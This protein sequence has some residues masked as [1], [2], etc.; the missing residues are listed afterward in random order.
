MRKTKII[1]T[2]GPS[3][4]DV[5]VL[6]QMIEAGMNVARFN[7]SHGGHGDHAEKIALVRKAAA[8]QG[9]IVGLMMDT[10]GPEIRTGALKNGRVILQK[11]L[12]FNLTTLPV[13][14][15]EAK[16]S[17]TCRR[18]INDVK[19]GDIILIDDGLIRLTVENITKTDIVCQVVNGGEL[20]EHKGINVP[21]IVLDIPFM[22]E[23]DKEDILFA[24]EQRVD[25][26]AASFVRK[27]QDVLEIRKLLE[28]R[29]ADIDIIAKIE[30]RQGVDNLDEI[31]K[32]AD[33]I[34]V[35]RGDLGV[36]IP[37][38]E[39]PLVQKR[40][41]Q[42][43]AQSG[44]AVIVATQMLES[45]I[46]NPSPTRAEVSD[47]ATAVFESADAIMLSGETAKG[48]YPVEV[49]RTMS[50]IAERVEESFPYED[51]LRKKYI[52]EGISITDAISYACCST[53]LSLD[54]G[55][56]ISITN[57]GY[58]SKM[59]SKYRPKATI[60][61]ATPKEENI[62]KLTIVWGVYPILIS[63]HKNS[64][65]FFD[66]AVQRALDLE[67]V[68][69]GEK[70]VLSAGMPV[71]VSGA[72]NMMKVQV[73]AEILFH[74]T[75]IGTEPVSGKVKIIKSKEDL[76]KV[77]NEDIIVTVSANTDFV[78]Y[79]PMIKALVAEEGGLTSD[80]AILGLNANIPVL[81]GAKNATKILQ[82][83]QLITI[84][85]LRGCVYQ[86]IVKIK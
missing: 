69:I 31:I 50:R 65:S 64:D 29:G 19:P 86:G 58:T 60:I 48:Q 41:I 57:S 43:C 63:D 67:Y 81:V 12:N 61:A 22:S 70:I 47:I 14:G 11:G 24:I 42:T 18:L 80:A 13:A 53:A 56:I 9:K 79:L 51:T 40:I 77:E 59:L 34:M 7:F 3:S 74:G 5:G 39:V 68:E 62:N 23:Q 38:E 16:V 52:K 30:N 28:N 72:T 55:T 20:G 37:A 21:G 46:T 84:D 85:T 75:G 83:N 76:E 73:V 4:S 33:G 6:E 45:M 44:K 54:I 8:K 26:I 15:D 10:K 82:D 27:A 25:F 17:V 49:V 71:G 66:D 32:V 1:A 78:R 35:A 2:I 36:E